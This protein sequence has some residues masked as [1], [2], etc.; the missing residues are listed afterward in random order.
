MDM[1]S[2]RR[3]IGLIIDDLAGWGFGDYIQSNV[4][5]GAATMARKYDVNLLCFAAGNLDSA[6]EWVRGRN[7]L[8]EFIDRNK[9]DG[10]IVLTTAIGLKVSSNRV[11]EKLEQY[12]GI[13]IVTIGDTF[14]EH[15]SVS[16]DN[17]QGMCGALEHIIQHHDR[18][19]IVF[20]KGPSG[21]TE[22]EDRFRAYCD[23]LKK[24]GIPY[25]G[26]L[27]LQGNFMFESGAVAISELH[28]QQITYDAVVAANDSMAIGALTEI[29]KI[30]GKLPEHL[31]IIGFDDIE[32][33]EKLSLTTVKQ[34][35]Y[36]EAQTALEMLVRL[37]NGERIEKNQLADTHLVIRSSCGCVPRIITE[38]TLDVDSIASG[39]KLST[40]Q[41]KE[42]FITHMDQMVHTTP[43]LIHP[44]MYRDIRG[45]L[46]HL[47]H[48]L[49]QELFF[50]KE[51]MFFYAWRS[52]IF[53][54]IQQKID[55][56][57]MHNALSSIRVLTLHTV[58]A[59]NANA[60]IKAENLFQM[61]RV[62]ISEAVQRTSF[63]LTYMSSLLS[64][65]LEQLGEQLGSHHLDT[66]PLME[67]IMR[68]FPKHGIR[69][70]YICLYD[71]PAHAM[72]TSQLML[73]YRNGERID[74]DTSIVRF[75]TNQLLPEDI[76]LEL[77]HYRH[78]FV[79]QTLHHSD[80]H[81]GYVIF[82]FDTAVNKAYELLRYRLSNTLRVSKLIQDVR[83]HS[84]ELES[85]VIARTR[86]LSLLNEELHKQSIRDDLTGLLNRR[87][88]MQRGKEAF[89]TATSRRTRLL[90]IYADL[91]KLKNINDS[92]GHSAGDEAIQ[93]TA[94]VLKQAF[95]STDI[96]SRLAGDEFTIIVESP[97][98]VNIEDIRQSIQ[99]H[100]DR[101]NRLHDKPFKL[102]ISLG[103]AEYHPDAPCTFDKLMRLAD[104]ALY[105]DKKG[106]K[107]SSRE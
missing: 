56:S 45:D 40:Q 17:Y 84:M 102:S 51:K 10:L 60:S 73:A 78:Q 38:T 89:E 57:F 18:R 68:E 77:A 101:I 7:I 27:V 95:R 36:S 12:R 79:I 32:P 8:F 97:D 43:G 81:I 1:N 41:M 53:H 50:D 47:P 62:Q 67:L 69:E 11:L 55:L 29:H 21:S 33:S 76:L 65:Q 14:A 15:Y 22:A 94:E 91:D 71:D 85:Q 3:T 35:F 6:N 103:F 25:D 16:I 19:N 107:F 9:V 30:D 31:S 34:S 75:P 63:S 92:Y 44:D 5:A 64:N 93:M 42:A 90:L 23:T 24:Y 87:G 104:E 72:G 58:A 80:Y 74:L 39:E 98:S 106:K 20:L 46:E 54:A 83:N 37:L 105:R 99:M 28:K 96:I 100:S 61:A 4:V 88:F 26:R 59:A 70:G 82:S 49:V 48:A 86:E 52:I 66:A 13:P 2:K